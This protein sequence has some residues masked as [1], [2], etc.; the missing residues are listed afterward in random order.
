L[1]RVIFFTEGMNLFWLGHCA[2]ANEL[3]ISSSSLFLVFFLC[4]SDLI[5]NL[6]TLLGFTLL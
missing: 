1:I 2:S 5:V 4:R 3:F 6:S